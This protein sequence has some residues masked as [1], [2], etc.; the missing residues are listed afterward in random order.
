MKIT[1]LPRFQEKALQKYLTEQN[2]GGDY[3]IQF[4]SSI[5]LNRLDSLWYGGGMVNIRYKNHIF[6]IE[7]IGDVRA[8]LNSK[9]DDST[10]VY[11]KDKSNNGNFASEMFSY[12][13]SDNSLNKITSDKHPAYYLEFDNNNWWECFV[14]DPQNEFHDLMW[15]LNDNGLFDGIS[16]VLTNLDETINNL[17]GA[18]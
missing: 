1:G 4:E 14:T 17:K 2:I 5:S 15:C 10:L 12:F 9:S 16:E 7:A 13:R 8:W 3:E 11:I 18:A 6:H